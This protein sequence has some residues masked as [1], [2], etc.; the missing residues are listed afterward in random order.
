M[1][2]ARHHRVRDLGP[3]HP[4][5]AHRV[6]PA[7]RRRGL[8]WTQFLRAQAGGVL[9]CDFLTVETNRLVPLYI[10]FVIELGRRRVWLTGITANPTGTWVAQQARELLMDMGAQADRF[11]MLIRDRDA[12][13]SAAFDHVFTTDGIRVVRA[14]VRAPKANAYAERWVRTVRTECLDWLL[15]RNR[16]HREHVLAI[17]VQHYNS[18]RPHRSIGL[19][20]PLPAHRP[21]AGTGRTGKVDRVDRLGGLLHEYRHAA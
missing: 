21:P 8:T 19:Q 13:F 10:L 5:S 18:E 11:H 14:P 1:R 9:A 16:R 3:E 2:E 7:P 15:I 17:Y 12:K 6:G 4:A 20:T